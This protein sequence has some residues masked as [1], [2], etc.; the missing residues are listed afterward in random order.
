MDD[1]SSPTFANTYGMPPSPN[2]YIMPGKRPVSSMVPSIVIDTDGNVRLLVGGSGG[3]KIITA[4]AL[5]T[6]PKFLILGVLI[7]F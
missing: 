3:P 1:F 6:M 5:V 2:N 7:L 4:V